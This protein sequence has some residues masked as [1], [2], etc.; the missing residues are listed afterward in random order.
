MNTYLGSSSTNIVK[1]L[2]RSQ[3]AV[4]LYIGTRQLGAE[5][6]PLDL[7]KDGKQGV[8]YNPS[9]KTTLFQD[10][11][12]T[13]P[14]TKDGDPVA[15]MRDK[16]GNGNHA[17]QTV[18]AERPVYKTDG[19]MHWLQ[20]DGVD[21]SLLI[22]NMPRKDGMYVAVGALTNNSVTQAIIGGLSNS[23]V[24][25]ANRSNNSTFYTSDTNTNNVWSSYVNGVVHSTPE[26]RQAMNP[27]LFL[28]QYAVIAISNAAMLHATFDTVYIGRMG[29]SGYFDG[30]ITNI[31][32]AESVSE[33]TQGEVTSYMANKSGVTL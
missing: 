23:R 20:F 14:V 28:S 30:N 5:F 4:A 12:G 17:T 22:T 10:V 25:Y 32:L 27:T 13:V 31:V 33:E 7:F 8:W 9:D 24:I 26:N 11:A 29:S 16:S 19:E 1:T 15:L 6:S 18:S 21:D 3:E 2:F